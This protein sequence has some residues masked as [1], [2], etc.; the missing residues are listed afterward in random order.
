MPNDQ[1]RREIDAAVA[2][3][4]VARRGPSV[5]SAATHL[6]AVM[7]ADAD[8]CQRSFERLAR[9]GFDR[10]VVVRLLRRLQEA[11]FLSKQQSGQGRA[12]NTYRLHLP[13][14]LP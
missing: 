8:V 10:T 13:P 5:S 3:Y 9:E 6:L 2:A 7:F 14:V 4:N 1:R 12:P 11:G